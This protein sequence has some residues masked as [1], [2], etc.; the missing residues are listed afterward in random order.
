MSNQINN[1]SLHHSTACRSDKL[2]V[3]YLVP[4]RPTPSITSSYHDV[5]APT[6]DVAM[7]RRRPFIT[8][9]TQRHT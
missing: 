9:V 5:S 1:P 2:P 6:H 7:L 8:A 4:W 3:E